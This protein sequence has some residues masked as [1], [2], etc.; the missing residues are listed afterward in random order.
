MGFLNR[1]FGRIL[2]R[3]DS[4][5]ESCPKLPEDWTGTKMSD[6]GRAFLIQ[7]E[8][9]K[10]ERQK[11]DKVGELISENGFHDCDHGRGGVIYYVEDG[12]LCEIG[13][14]IILAPVDLRKWERPEGKTI[15]QDKQL[16]ILRKLRSW[17]KEQ[18]LRN[19]ID[20]PTN[21]EFAD[22][23]CAKKGCNEQRIKGSAY[24][25]KHYDLNLLRE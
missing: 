2:K 21:I 25:R 19:N 3:S 17:L 5:A 8:Q 9:Y 1:L 10:V 14:D 13:Y 11:K 7:V 16:E 6:E 4:G 24:C 18:K 22:R 12:Y 20:L 15:P 23:R